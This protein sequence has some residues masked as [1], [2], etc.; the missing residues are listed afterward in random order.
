VAL[1]IARELDDPDAYVVTIS[2]I[3]ASAIS[4]RSSTTT[5]CRRTSCSIAAATVEQLL[6]QR[7]PRARRR[8][9]QVAPAAAVRQALNLMSSWEVSQ[10]PSSRTANRWAAWWS[11]R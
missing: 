6:L 5:G 2:A 7:R 8:L 10:I 3:P 1:D 11:R 4:R 9:V